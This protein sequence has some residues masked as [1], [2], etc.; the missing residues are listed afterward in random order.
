MAPLV[1]AVID[2]VRSR[3][4][5]CSRAGNA[6]DAVFREDPIDICQGQSPQPR[7]NQVSRASQAWYSSSHAASSTGTMTGGRLLC[8]THRPVS[9][10]K[11]R[12]AASSAANCEA[13][14]YPQIAVS[15]WT[16]RHPENSASTV[17]RVA[18]AASEM[19]ET[20][21]G[22]AFHLAGTGS[23]TA[24]LSLPPFTSDHASW[25]WSPL[26]RPDDKRAHVSPRLSDVTDWSG[27]RRSTGRR[28]IRRTF[29]E[30]GWTL[31]AR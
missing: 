25:S 22:I 24:S 29:R 21:T 3:L 4:T 30:V 15:P 20:K 1:V 8:R 9:S 6:V 31:N 17:Q 27:W 16:S 26:A 18:Y 19:Y 12:R 13:S 23:S 14:A 2:S 5:G 11:A 10:A 7:G 28:V